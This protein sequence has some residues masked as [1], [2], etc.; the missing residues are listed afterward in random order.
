MV[1]LELVQAALREKNLKFKVQRRNK[2]LFNTKNTKKHEGKKYIL[3]R[4]AEDG[5]GAAQES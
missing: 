3:L 5:G 2:R 1:Q 4:K